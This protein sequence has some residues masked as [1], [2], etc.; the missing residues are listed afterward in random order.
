M[1]SLLLL[2]K[3]FDKYEF[4]HFDLGVCRNTWLCCGIVVHDVSARMW[5]I[6]CLCYIL[7]SQNLFFQ[8]LLLVVSKNCITWFTKLNCKHVVFVDHSLVFLQ[9]F[10]DTGSCKLWQTPRW[11]SPAVIIKIDIIAVWS[12]DEWKDCR[13]SEVCNTISA[14]PLY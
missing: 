14:W 1:T 8:K 3:I 7:K 2:I 12:S 11:P 5:Q 10:L 13:K 4:L 9:L 6:D